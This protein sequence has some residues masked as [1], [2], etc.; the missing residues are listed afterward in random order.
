MKVQGKLDLLVDPRVILGTVSLKN[1][2]SN[3]FI[4]YTK[5]Y[6]QKGKSKKRRRNEKRLVG[7]FTMFGLTLDVRTLSHYGINSRRII[8][9]ENCPQLI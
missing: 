8:P 5:D 6:Q 2:H 4:L 1:L 9:D 7:L 3:G